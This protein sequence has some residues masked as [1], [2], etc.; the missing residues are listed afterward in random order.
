VMTTEL[1]GTCPDDVTRSVRPHD[2]QIGGQAARCS[3]A[4]LDQPT[5]ARVGPRQRLRER[6]RFQHRVFGSRRAG[7]FGSSSAMATAT[8]SA[9]GASRR[10]PRR[11]PP[12]SRPWCGP[13]APGAEMAGTTCRARPLPRRRANRRPRRRFGGAA[14]GVGALQAWIGHTGQISGPWRRIERS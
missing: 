6:A 5:V 9:S 12:P 2:E 11:R 10:A 7:A 3:P 8:R 14:G 13:S 4:E 1:C